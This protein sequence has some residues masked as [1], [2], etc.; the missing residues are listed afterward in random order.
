MKNNDIYL[1]EKILVLSKETEMKLLP[2]GSLIRYMEDEWVL[3]LGKNQY[4]SLDFHE[5]P[6]VLEH[7]WIKDPYTSCI[8]QPFTSEEKKL[9]WIEKH[10]HFKEKI[11]KFV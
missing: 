4:L 9:L 11:L 5:K 2:K 8:Y 3:Y 7:D 10:P 6:K 1:I